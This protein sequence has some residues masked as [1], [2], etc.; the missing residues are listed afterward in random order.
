[1]GRHRFW[2]LFL[3]AWF[4][5]PGTAIGATDFTVGIVNGSAGGQVLIPVDLTSG[6]QPIGVQFDIVYDGSVLVSDPVLD[7]AAAAA[8]TIESN[9]VNSGRRRVVIYSDTNA[10]IGDGVIIEIPFTVAVG[11]YGT[12]QVVDLVSVLVSDSSGQPIAPFGTTAGTLDI[13]EIPTNLGSLTLDTET[14]EFQFDLTGEEG[15][16]IRI[17]A[18]TDLEVWESLGEFVITD[19]GFSFTDPNA[20]DFTERFYRAVE[21]E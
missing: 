5:T 19:G 12:M 7:G 15:K 4:A 16:T 18:S 8:H 14:G 9:A 13:I 1:M 11:S 10:V 3:A 20:G 21:V 2:L 6:D 17:E